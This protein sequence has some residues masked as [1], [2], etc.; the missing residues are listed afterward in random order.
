MTI[1][2]SFVVKYPRWFANDPS[3][4]TTTSS[5]T[6]QS[7]SVDRTNTTVF[8]FAGTKSNL[9][10]RRSRYLTRQVICPSRENP[11]NSSQQDI[12]RAVVSI[13]MKP[14]TLAAE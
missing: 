6:G 2:R 3:K 11:Q 7:A 9:T 8:K 13:F 14:T 1:P 5:I 12:D 10:T 4:T